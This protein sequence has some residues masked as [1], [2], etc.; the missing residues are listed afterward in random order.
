MSADY[1]FRLDT[2][3]MLRHA[4]VAGAC[5]DYHVEAGESRQFCAGCGFSLSAHVI[6][7][8]REKL[9]QSCGTC[10]HGNDAEAIHEGQ[11]HCTKAGGFFNGKLMLMAARCPEWAKP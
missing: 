11:T 1:G 8:Q 9:A 4:E 7:A 2:A 6:V 5:Q 3:H 10:A